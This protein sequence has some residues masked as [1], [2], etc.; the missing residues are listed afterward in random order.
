[1]IMPCGIR[2]YGNA[3]INNALSSTELISSER[4]EGE[5]LLSK[6]L[7]VTIVKIPDP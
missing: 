5:P 1:V 2:S 3:L 4:I 7:E 6:R